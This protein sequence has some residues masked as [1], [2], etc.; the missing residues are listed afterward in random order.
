M[1][2]R[3]RGIICWVLAFMM[4][5]NLIPVSTIAYAMEEETEISEESFDGEGEIIEEADVAENPGEA[6]NEP[7][8][9]PVVSEV[10]DTYTFTV[11][12]VGGIVEPNSSRTISWQTSFTPSKVE[13]YYYYGYDRVI[14]ATLTQNLK[15]Q[16]SYPVNYLDAVSS[17]RDWYVRAYFD[18]DAHYRES[19]SFRV[20]RESLSFVTQ[21]VGGTVEPNSS[22]TIS[23]QTNFTP[24][25][26]EIYYYAGYD[27]V[28]VATLTQNLNRQMSYSVSYLDASYMSTRDWHVSVYYNDDLYKE[29]DS[30]HVVRN[31]LLFETQPKGGNIEPESSMTLNWQTNFMPSKVEIMVYYGYNDAVVATLTQ[32]LSRQMSY[33]V[34][35][36]DAAYSSSANWYVRV[37]YNDDLYRDSDYF[38]ISRVA[39]TFTQKPSDA[40]IPVGGNVTVRWATNFTV[41]RYE[42]CLYNDGY[43]T[44]KS[45]SGSAS[46]YTFSYAQTPPLTYYL[47]AYYGE[48]ETDYVSTFFKVTPTPSGFSTLPE[49][50]LAFTPEASS[51]TMHWA[52]NISPGRLE[53]WTNKADTGS[54]Q[55]KVTTL[56]N[57]ATSYPIPRDE[58]QI[59]WL[60][61]YYGTGSNDFYYSNPVKTRVADYEADMVGDFH[62][63]LEPGQSQTVN[64]T[65]NF[66]PT[67]IEVWNEN[68]LGNNLTYVETIDGSRRSYTIDYDFDEVAWLYLFYNDESG[69]EQHK[70]VVYYVHHTVDRAFTVQPPETANV[71]YQGTRTLS[72]QTNFQPTRIEIIRTY[73][74]AQTWTSDEELIATLPNTRTS[75]AF[76]AGNYYH[77]R[78]YYMSK[79]GEGYVDSIGIELVEDNPAFSARISGGTVDPDETLHLTWMT[80]F[81][82]KAVSIGYKTDTGFFVSTAEITSGFARTMSYDLPYDNAYNGKMY[83]RARYGDDAFDYVD[84][85]DFNVTK[86]PRAFVIQPT[87]GTINPEGSLALNWTM[88]FT[89]TAVHVGWY[90]SAGEWITKAE[91]TTGLKKNMSYN[92]P[93]DTA[94][95]GDMRLRAYYSSDS[96]ME[97]DSFTVTKVAHLFTVQPTGG[98]IYP[99]TTRQIQWTTNFVPRRVEIGYMNGSTWVSKGSVGTDLKKSMSYTLDY[100]NAY[101]SDKW[102]IRA[103][104]YQG[105]T[106]AFLSSGDFSVEA[107]SAYVCGDNL[108]ATLDQNTGTLTFSGTGA[109]YDYY[110]GASGSL[111]RA[112]WNEERSSIKKVVIP[113]GVTCIGD[114]AFYYCSKMT[115]VSIPASVTQIGDSAF[116]SCSTLSYVDYDGFTAQWNVIDIGTGNSKL[117]GAS[118]AYLYRNGTVDR[119]SY[120]SFSWRLNGATGR[121]EIYGTGLYQG[122]VQ[123]PW[124][125]WAQYIAELDLD[126]TYIWEEA[127]RDCTGV[128][129]V[130]LSDSLSS[131]DTLAFSDCTQITD[132]YYN[133]PLSDWEDISIGSG[134]DPLL[135]AE[136]HTVAHEAQLT[137]ILSWSVDDAGLLRIWFDDS[138]MG[139]AEDT[140]I[141]DYSYA[142]STSTAPW[143]EDYSDKITAISVESGVTSIGSNAFAGL[144]KARFIDIADTVTAI[145]VE[146]FMD[147]SS[148]EDFT[149]PDSILLIKSGAFQNCSYLEQIHLPDSITS[150]GFRIFR[151]CGNLEKVWLPSQI[152]AIPTQAFY[153]CSLL[154]YIEIPETVTS[155]GANAFLSCTE[156]ASETGHV[157]YRGSSGQW[158]QIN[159]S[160]IGNSALLNAGN[161]HFTPEELRIDAENFPD[162][163]FRTYVSNNF[164]TDSSGWLTEAECNEAG[165]INDEV[166]DYGSLK[167]I[168]YFPHMTSI[169]I[170]AAPGLSSVDLSANTE[171]NYVDFS[172][173]GNI[174]EINLSG[175]NEL[176]GLYLSGN[177]LTEVDLSGLTDLEFLSVSANPLAELD[178]DGLSLKELYVS[179]LSDLSDLDIS[180]QEELYC[181]YC[182]GS[183]IK[184]LDLTGNPE[185]MEAYLSGTKTDKTLDGI[186]YTEYEYGTNQLLAID[187]DCICYTEHSGIR[188]DSVNFPDPD[189]RKYVAADLDTNRSGYL[190][191]GEIVEITQLDLAYENPMAV[192]SLKGIEYFTRL[193]NLS[194]C[195]SPDLEE[196]DLSANTRLQSI[197]MWNTGLESLDVSTLK[198]ESI[199]CSRNALDELV[200]GEQPDLIFLGCYGNEFDTLDLSGCPKLIDTVQNGTKTNVTNNGIACTEYV[201]GESGLNGYLIV[202]Q[203]TWL[204]LSEQQISDPIN[205]ESVSLAL[206]EK[207]EAR[208]YVYVPDSELATTDINLTFNGETTTYHAADITPK[209]YNKKPCRIVSIDTFAKQM[210]DDIRVT[211]TKTGT[212]ELK[213]LEYKGNPVTAGLHYKIEDYFK[214]AEAN[215]TD[216][217]LIDLVHKI[218]NYGKYAQ[219]QFN[220]YNRESFDEADPI[221]EDYNDSRL[222][223]YLVNN[224]GSASGIEYTSGSLELESDTGLRVYYKLTGSDAIGSYTF[225][226]DSTKVTPVKKGTQYYVSIKNIPA[227]LMSKAHTV[228]VT[229][230]AGN[231]LTTTYS[232][233]SYPAAVTAAAAAPETLK[234]LCR[235]IDLYAE[236]ALAYFGE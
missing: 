36:E 83:V 163:Q 216:E 82:P 166:N 152:T 110:Y 14:V 80:N 225:K 12:P 178:L 11:Q 220:N 234:N 3:I 199:S 15:Q 182:C 187:R 96:F 156:L 44:Y 121:L 46:D 124:Y 134:N 73:W 62:L 17:S 70:N 102:R 185:L 132:V 19:D 97:S 149:L 223:P 87:G 202:D 9:V 20:V 128:K 107:L 59:Y 49:S 99:W 160:T 126:V 184:E 22:R 148:L 213:Y 100:D 4:V 118:I 176:K 25:K 33:S 210:R 224:A 51:V 26:V 154:D 140:D 172:S 218:D 13:I 135:D 43:V 207:I 95:H 30:F 117:T 76:P 63:Y 230:K 75:Y 193:T 84:S 217:S 68:V 114:Y 90:N 106:W 42:I 5:N 55:K 204:Y 153:E 186:D 67:R 219:I 18:N 159:I 32:N 173:C 155:I 108:T 169:L 235:A 175:L 37:Y 34:S 105:T 2:K 111:I 150:L 157:Y 146:A 151:D 24:S 233:L 71:P 10:Q 88:N 98:K 113:D 196:M 145:G 60:R 6:E 158:K 188:I 101:S 125:E 45:L 180:D 161:M 137:S 57:T 179:N 72:W 195:D 53:L 56:N 91:I 119:G 174:E 48:G 205:I 130:Y 131:V 123:G 214:A 38:K 164:D 236:A 203:N 52:L 74:N 94:I 7:A 138:L 93:Y 194:V 115:S 227:R 162:A 89:P 8:A 209:T 201:L 222:T 77:V 86:T 168:E 211:V 189:F 136:L 65:A 144:K 54:Y 85:Y 109:M 143:F 50:E 183:G 139:D 129:E 177:K 167:G 41:K 232:G 103:Y 197:D 198:V 47:L 171:L 16:M 170:D 66:S 64:F 69:T 21:P 208:F 229:D 58:G 181:L 127:F 29:S 28:I 104:Y 78:A 192:S 190:S 40:T 120:G 141:P 231:T 23:W 61:V 31:S 147:C 206:K 133:G 79:T 200:L 81:V 191:D 142:N 212:T 35:Y 228:T 39:R 226:V 122:H 112:P 27:K 1:S 92:L 116:N 165:D 221:P 215:S